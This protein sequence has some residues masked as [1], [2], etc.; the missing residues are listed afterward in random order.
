MSTQTI[1]NKNLSFMFAVGILS[2]NTVLKNQSFDVSTWQ[3]KSIG[4]K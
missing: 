4:T 3:G 1:I 2:S